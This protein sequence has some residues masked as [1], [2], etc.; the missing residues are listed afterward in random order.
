MQHQDLICKSGHLK[1]YTWVIV[2][3]IIDLKG[4]ADAEKD[5]KT[6]AIPLLMRNK[7]PVKLS[8]TG[9]EA[10]DVTLMP[11][12]VCALQF[13]SKFRNMPI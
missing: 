1:L 6:V 4:D 8:D 10:L 3:N 12:V 9:D 5:S 2:V 11:E 13:Q 7:L